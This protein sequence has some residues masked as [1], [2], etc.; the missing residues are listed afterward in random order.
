MDKSWMTIKNIISK[1]YREGVT[2]FVDF[3]VAN[4]Y[5]DDEI[6]CP[7]LR[8][9]N[10]KHHVSIV[11]AFHLVHNGIAPSYK[12]WVHH[13][14]TIPV[15][16]PY[17]LNENG[18]TT[19]DELDELPKNAETENVHK[20]EKLMK[21]ANRELYPGCKFTL[22][23]F[24][25]KLLHVKVLNKWSNKSFDALWSLGYVPIQAFKND[26]TLFWKVSEHL[27]KCP[28]CEASGYK[29]ND[30]KGKRIPHKILGYFPLIPR[31]QRLYMLSKT[32]LDM[33]WH[34][35]KRVDDGVLRHPIDGEAW[36]DFDRQYP[37]FARDAQNVRLG[38]ASDGFNL[39]GNMRNSYSMEP[40]IVVPYNLPPWKCMKV[41]YSML[42][43][44]IL[45]P[46]ALG[47]IIDVYL[48]PLIDELK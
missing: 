22:L 41:P 44:L 24:V 36:K 19:D 30:G 8:C 13:G 38:L 34:K 39:F 28:V 21:D 23:S 25:I 47:K 15:N 20:F 9:M 17:R 35:E 16:Q 10:V 31:L 7:G 1:E 42:S 2:K 12:T 29:L 48:R 6:R 26:L 32:C 14:E 37:E 3:A 33:R 11:V 27:E 4:S 18:I 46:Q 40:V 43:L 5:S 45:G